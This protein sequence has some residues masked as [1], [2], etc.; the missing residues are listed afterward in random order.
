MTL[1][2][3]KIFDSVA[4]RRS[5]TKAAEELHMSQPAVS[6]QLKLLERE[7]GLRFHMRISQGVELTQ[8]GRAFL[9]A[10]RPILV[11]VENVQRSFEGEPKARKTGSL[12]VGG[13]RSLSV[14]FLP[15]ILMAFKQTHPHVQCMLETADSHT[16]E[17]RVLNSEVEIALITDPF[18]S[19]HVVLEPYKEQELVAFAPPRSPLIRKEMTLKE[20]SEIPLVVRKRGKTLRELGRRGYMLNIAVECDASEAVKAA[21]HMGMGVGVLLRDAI[22]LDVIK[23]DLR[24]INVPELKKIK[25]ESFVAYPLHTPLSRDAQNFL[26]ILRRR[27]AGGKK[28]RGPKRAA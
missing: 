1:H 16:M 5:I 17:R 6:Q 12:V 15:Q 2:Q 20:L 7:F 9:D 23:G 10:V 14:S 28:V 24:I 21:V 19:P 3:L 18:Y 13:S 26:N 27:K 4:K 11:Q 8:R 22:E 25:I